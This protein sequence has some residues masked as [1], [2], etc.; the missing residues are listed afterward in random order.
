MCHA[1]SVFQEHHLVI[2][3]ITLPHRLLV[4]R[5]VLRETGRN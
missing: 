3:V 4:V 5:K 1:R 2:L